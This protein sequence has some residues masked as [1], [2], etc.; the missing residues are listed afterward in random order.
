LY[1]RNTAHRLSTYF[2]MQGALECYEMMSYNINLLLYPRLQ[3]TGAII[4]AKSKIEINQL[5]GHISNV[6]QQN[7]DKLEISKKLGP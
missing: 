4:V 5:T 1:T 2:D 3:K 6:S 7:E